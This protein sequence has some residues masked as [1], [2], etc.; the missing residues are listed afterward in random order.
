MS[1]NWKELFAYSRALDEFS[2]QLQDKLIVLRVDK[3]CAAH[4]GNFA[5]GRIDLLAQLAKHIRSQEILL[6]CESIAIR[7]ECSKNVTADALSRLRVSATH[8]DKHPHRS[9][10]KKPFHQLNAAY[11]PCTIDGFVA[12]DGHNALLE[13]YWTESRS[14]V[15]NHDGRELVWVFPPT[16]IILPLL[17]FLDDKRREQ[18]K[19]NVLV[20]LPELPS[21][22][23]FRYCQHYKRVA[24]FRAGS[25][26]FREFKQGAWGK[27]PPT[28]YPWMLLAARA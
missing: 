2:V 7:L 8:R 17:Q 14:F 22:P 24:R 3:T 20:L 28:K 16:D 13:R 18:E 12:D 9:L 26:L 4:Y 5:S 6:G 25:D 19:L 1:I 10:K 27:A 15:E 11:G 23:W 21:T